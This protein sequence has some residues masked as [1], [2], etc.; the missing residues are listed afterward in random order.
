M[1]RLDLKIPRLYA[2]VLERGPQEIFIEHAALPRTRLAETLAGLA[3]SAASAAKTVQ[4]LASGAVSRDKYVLEGYLRSLG[5]V[6]RQFSGAAC[7]AYEI[8]SSTGT[9]VLWLVD[10]VNVPRD[11]VPFAACQGLYLIDAHRCPESVWTMLRKRASRAV[12]AGEPS[13]GGDWWYKAVS[14][15][16]TDTRLILRYDARQVAE[17]YPD[18]KS[19]VLPT[20]DPDYKR[21]MMLA[22]LGE[23][24]SLGLY[25]FLQYMWDTIVPEEAHWNW[26]IKYVCDEIEAV[27]RRVLRREPKQY[28]LIINIPPGST[29]STIATVA[30]QPWMWSIDRTIR[31]IY[32]SYSY[33]LSLYLAG[34]SRRLIESEKY[35]RLY[36][37]VILD[38]ASKQNLITSDGGQRFATSVGGSVTGMHGH[39][40]VV[41]DP[42]NPK[43]AVSKAHLQTANDWVDHTLATRKVDKK[44]T[45]II[46]IMQRLHQDD[47]TGHMLSQWIDG[48]KHICLPATLD[49][50]VKPAELKDNYTSSGLFDPVRMPLDVLQ[51]LEKELGTYAYAGQFLQA[52]VPKGG[53]TFRA[54]EIE[55]IDKP[56]PLARV[57][58]YW[59]KAGTAAK[60]CFT[61]GCK[62]ARTRTGEYVILDIIRGQW[63]ANE[64]ERIMRQTAMIDGP[65]VR[66]GI[67]QEPGSGGKESAQNSL[68]NLAG[69]SIFIDRPKGDK[70]LRADP[71]ADQVNGGN[72]KMLKGEW[73]TEYLEEMR[74]FP[75]SKYKDQID[76]S[77]GAFSMLV[78]MV[79]KV[80]AF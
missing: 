39:I 10:V 11:G 42:L 32:G 34:K 77:S 35:K 67:E 55:I 9:S 50:E 58:R 7:V 36:P 20:S 6:T 29:K 44:L 56:P 21:M 53:G 8:E 41:D 62:M 74:H 4:V 40:I 47:T 59:D 70:E 22:D 1:P 2:S 69:F 30:L 17:A 76:A 3:L 79:M 65:Y 66:I 19:F 49:G 63:E 37:G 51:K 5:K 61:V 24:S 73:N 31:G 28:D 23:G 64:R 48:I 15:G 78:T 46:V 75:F 60:G 52:P 27:A 68:R 33:D 57:A 54:D 18:Q 14:G 16:K 26:H 45:P 72:V 38:E 25:D 71:F 43:E 13:R 12:V 80:G